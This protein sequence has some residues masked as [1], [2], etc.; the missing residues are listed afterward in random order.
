V[1][2][3][4][5]VRPGLVSH[6]VARKYQSEAKHHATNL[7]NRQQN[8]PRQQLETEQRNEGLKSAIATDNKGFKLLEK[9]GY[10][11]GTAIGKKGACLKCISAVTLIYSTCLCVIQLVTV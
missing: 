8:K 9:M 11:P 10:K 1:F 6:S 4:S 5:D 2:D 3:D 7:A